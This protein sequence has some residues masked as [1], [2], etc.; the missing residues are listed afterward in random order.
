VVYCRTAG[1]AYLKGPDLAAAIDADLVAQ[2]AACLRYA[3][4]HGLRPVEGQWL[5]EDRCGGET[6][7]PGRPGFGALLGGGAR[8]VLVVS[9]DRVAGAGVGMGLRK[10]GVTVRVV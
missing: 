1:P 4:K 9:R 2:K 3:K 8:N 5:F 7:P 10:R 6:S